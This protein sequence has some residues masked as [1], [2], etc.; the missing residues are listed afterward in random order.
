M[1]NYF[2]RFTYCS[3]LLFPNF[4]PIILSNQ[5]IIYSL[6]LANY[7]YIIL[8]L[9]FKNFEKH[10]DDIYISSQKQQK[11][12][13]MTSARPCAFKFNPKT[14]AFGKVNSL[15]MRMQCRVQ[16]PLCTVTIRQ[17]IIAGP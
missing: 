15:Y 12:I 17:C 9:V 8:K 1:A 2:Q 13:A 3:I 5:P 4:Q 6:K 11:L 7:S 10:S 16:K 14:T